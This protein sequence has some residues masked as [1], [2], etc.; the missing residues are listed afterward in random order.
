MKFAIAAHLIRIR[1]EKYIKICLKYENNDLFDVLILVLGAEKF[2]F[3][4]NM[5][6]CT[7]PLHLLS[8]PSLNLVSSIFLYSPP[9]CLSWEQIFQP[10]PRSHGFSEFVFSS[11]LQGYNSCVQ[12][13]FTSVHH[14]WRWAATKY[15]S[16]SYK[17]E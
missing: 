6:I 11:T 1:R 4:Y 14:N 15:C 9:S 16:P 10:G 7:H 17:K 8:V 3:N 12:E 13:H 2:S 5:D